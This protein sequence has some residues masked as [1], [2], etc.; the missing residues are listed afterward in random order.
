MYPTWIMEAWLPSSEKIS[1]PGMC[2]A[3]VKRVVSL[4]TKQL[5]KTRA[6]SLRCS[7]AS[8]ASSSSCSTELPEMFLLDS[9]EIN[10]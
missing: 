3:R 6:A 5:V 2:L 1:Q 4:A 10:L 7:E 9:Q 8:S